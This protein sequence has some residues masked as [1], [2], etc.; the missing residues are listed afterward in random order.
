MSVGNGL[1]LNRVSFAFGG[2]FYA[3]PYH[4]GVASY[5][6]EHGLVQADSRLY[7]V[8]SGTVPAVLL[9]CGVDVTNDGMPQAMRANDKHIDGRVFGPYLSP[10]AV[11]D[12]FELFAEVLPA[13]A[14]ERAS[15]KL[16]IVLTEL[17]SL[18]RRVISH[19]PTREALMDA[20]K[21]SMAIPGHGVP[22]AYRAHH[23]DKRLFLDGGFVAN[24]IDDDRPGY[25]TI[26]IGVFH[27]HAA[28]FP[29]PRGLHIC[30]H[31]YLPWRMRLWVESD[32][33]R[34]AWHKRGYDDARAYFENGAPRQRRRGI[35]GARGMA[36]NSSSTSRRHS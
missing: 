9:A 7:G 27:F 12:S 1:A 3:W 13:D 23:L 15:G 17:P 10:R 36:G 34:H 31:E 20:L 2:G 26:R 6:Q 25:R 30:P 5:L 33:V 14:H 35:A 32:Q 19:F 29:V 21:A 11:T 16:C 28:L 18:R 22:I 8:S 24:V 4:C